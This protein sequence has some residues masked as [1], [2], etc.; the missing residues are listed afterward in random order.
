MLWLAVNG[1]GK[2]WLKR[3][4]LNFCDQ[5]SNFNLHDVI[6]TEMTNTEKASQSLVY[7]LHYAFR[8]PVYG[9]NAP[10]NLNAYQGMPW[11]S[12]YAQD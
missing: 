5:K 1:L 11:K 2:C 10:R 3:I 9:E 7:H 6:T 12:Q 4:I 8:R